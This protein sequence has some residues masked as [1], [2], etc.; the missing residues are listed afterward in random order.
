MESLS[1][2]VI[3][4][5]LVTEFPFLTTLK[6]CDIIL[7]EKYSMNIPECFENYI[8]DTANFK[9]VLHPI[10]LRTSENDD[11][12]ISHY[13]VSQ[14]SVCRLLMRLDT[15]QK[16]IL[17]ILLDKVIENGSD[18]YE[19]GSLIQLI[20]MQ[21]RWLSFIRLEHNSICDSLLQALQTCSVS[22]QKELIYILP[23]L[24]NEDQIDTV[25]SQLCSLLISEKP[26]ISTIY[27][28]LQ[29]IS[30]TSNQIQRYRD[31]YVNNLTTCNI[32]DIPSIV[33]FL[34][35]CTDHDICTDIISILRNNIKPNT[36][37]SDDVN[38]R[39]YELM[40][41]E[42]IS[43]ATNT[44][45][46]LC[47]QY[48]RIL[49]NT[50]SSNYLFLDYWM[51]YILYANPQY[52]N[53]V[54]FVFPRKFTRYPAN[55]T[56]HLDTLKGHSLSLNKYY[57]SILA[58]I[59]ELGNTSS[60]RCREIAREMYVC[61]FTEFSDLV[62]QQE[63]ISTLVCNITTGAS[64]PTN[65]Y[66]PILSLHVLKDL[67]VSPTDTQLNVFRPFIR[68]LLDYTDMMTEKQIQVLFEVLV[69][70]SLIDDS[71]G[72]GGLDELTILTRKYL[73]RPMLRQKRVGVIGGVI[74]MKEFTYKKYEVPE[75]YK[76]PDLYEQEI[77]NVTSDCIRFYK[78]LSSSCSQ[79]VDLKIYLYTQLS[80]WVKHAFIPPLFLFEL[81]SRIRSEFESLYIQDIQ[82]T[83]PSYT[84]MYI[85]ADQIPIDYQYNLDQDNTTIALNLFSLA[86]SPSLKTRLSLYLL[87]ANLRLL[88]ITDVLNNPEDGLAG[89][90]GL[91][92]CPILSPREST[93]FKTYGNEEKEC[94]YI[95]KYATILWITEL[96]NVF[97]LEKDTDIRIKVCS[98]LNLLHVL[99]GEFTSL[100]TCFSSLY[101]YT[102]SA[103]VTT[104]TQTKSKSSLYIPLLSPDFIKILWWR[105]IQFNLSASPAVSS[106]PSLS[107][108]SLAR[109]LK[110]MNIYITLTDEAKKK[111]SIYEDE[112]IDIHQLLTVWGNYK[113]YVSLKNVMDYI[114]SIITGKSADEVDL[115]GKSALYDCIH[116]ILLIYINTFSIPT[117]YNA[118][119]PYIYKIFC[120]YDSD[121]SQ[122]ISQ[123][124]LESS[125][126]NGTQLLSSIHSCYTYFSD[127]LDIITSND[128][129][130][131][132]ID[133]VNT[134]VSIYVDMYINKKENEEKEVLLAYKHKEGT[135]N[136]LR[137]IQQDHEGF[138]PITAELSDLCL[139]V[140]KKMTLRT[141]GGSDALF[142]KKLLTL[143]VLY[144]KDVLHTI[145]EIYQDF[146]SMIDQQTVPFPSLTPSSLHIY[147]SILIQLLTQEYTY[148]HK[149]IVGSDLY[150]QAMIIQTY[151]VSI[152]GIIA[153][154]KKFDH[155]VIISSSLRYYT[156]F[157]SLFLSHSLPILSSL[158]PRDQ[159]TVISIIRSMQKSTRQVQALCSHSKVVK[160]T[161][162]SVY[163][164]KLKK[165]L[166]SYLFEI[167]KLLGDNG[168]IEAFWLG[169]LKTRHID[170]SEVQVE[171]ELE[172]DDDED[173]DINDDTTTTN[174][175]D[176]N[177]NNNEEEDDDD[178][179]KVISIH[180]QSIKR[181]KSMNT[182]EEKNGYIQ[183]RKR[184]MKRKR[185][186]E[187]IESVQSSTKS[188]NNAGIPEEEEEEEEEINIQDLL[189]SNDDDEAEEEEED[190]EKENNSE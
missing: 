120:V 96:L 186:E 53:Y 185:Q 100:S 174:N 63:L 11:L 157:I 47:K 160:D 17:D 118:I 187:E 108:Y 51:Y 139:S 173:K 169:N 111:K 35:S 145:E 131:V 88:A 136:L 32:Q 50:D 98:R 25:F 93:N 155:K 177:N 69:R 8:A 87:P 66:L 62:H 6:N 170:G 190:D 113:I 3:N 91:L 141:A 158:F 55:S 42:Y 58:L 37:K 137:K 45:T 138:C 23:E 105:D 171:E 40:M 189:A 114:I 150:T 168:C 176:N 154:T 134:L 135:Y 156:Q 175:N 95:C 27:T 164:P 24:I 68:G 117:V 146:K 73:H 178:E 119:E 86:I 101:I 110:D 132:L 13:G 22:V 179:D 44:H 34:L 188:T 142:L 82:V 28:C 76:H 4:E 14:D 49:H 181:S 125:D 172:E 153:F 70:L 52:T 9:T 123:P 165:Y 15:L 107:I 163:I 33:N 18:E 149:H 29:N 59:G 48:M 182:K 60:I 184:N 38:P 30:L 90:D 129:N 79:E 124:D 161:S 84:S 78:L 85:H 162:M 54:R 57:S 143:Y 127:M 147:Y 16:N 115:A 130:I 81:N 144:S 10:F 94:I 2:Q 65:N 97:I 183:K 151:C 140:L 19:D 64:T 26:L 159:K 89:I 7:S 106:S 133:W 92:G 83:V 80:L 61:L 72:G 102:G 103:I 99:E 12:Q 21:F 104:P 75:Y 46:N 20:L 41:V 5:E 148:F 56:L 31:T 122:K 128:I 43:I 1:S 112:M 180:S 74:S 166:E 36:W 39:D 67:T 109:I 77:M 152:D 126:H 121:A 116:S 167:K 71:R